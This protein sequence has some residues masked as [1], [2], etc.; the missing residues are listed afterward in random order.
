[1]LFGSRIDLCLVST[2]SRVT[3]TFW[4]IRP[5]LFSSTGNQRFRYTVRFTSTLSFECSCVRPISPISYRFPVLQH[6][7]TIAFAYFSRVRS[8]EFLS[9][10]RSCCQIDLVRVQFVYFPH[11]FHKFLDT[12]TNFFHFRTV[13]S[14][15]SVSVC[16]TAITF[17]YKLRFRRSIY[18]NRS[19][20]NSDLCVPVLGGFNNFRNPKVASEVRFLAPH[21]FRNLRK[22]PQATSFTC[23]SSNFLWL[24]LCAPK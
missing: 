8:V 12:A 19:E 11:H 6:F 3:R 16:K 7:S 17:V 4:K 9:L 2:K 21:I 10:S 13:L 5:P 1:M 24:L 22:I 23:L 14:S 18:Q 20:K 15:N